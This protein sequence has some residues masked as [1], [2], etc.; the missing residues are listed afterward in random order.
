MKILKTIGLVTVIL[1]IAVL[2]IRFFSGSEDIWLCQN[3]QWIKHGQPSA[4]RPIA[5]C[6]QTE[7]EGEILVTAPLAN[8]RVNSPIKVQGRARGGWFFEASFPAQLLFQG[9]IISQ[10][11]AR[12][13]GDW[14]TNDFVP[15][16]ATLEPDLPRLWEALGTSK[17]TDGIELS[18]VIVLKR[19]NPS[20][21]PQYDKKIEIP[22]LISVDSGQFI[23]V[24][25][26]FNNGN[27][28]PAASCDKVFPVS[29]RVAKTA[30]VAQAALTEVLAGPS[31]KEKEQ[32]YFTNINPGVKIQKL[33]IKEGVARVDFDQ[34][35]AEAVGGSCRVSAIRAQITGTLKQFATVKD[36]II[37][38]NGRSQDIL[39]P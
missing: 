30:A 19:D 38:I 8:Q 18:A 37:S 15:F 7:P 6:G 31:D 24:K 10:T 23:M 20:G 26:F 21:L 12:A 11:M 28:D 9:E 34:T 22:V 35:L 33:T 29:R 32:G 2:A 4:L 25:A 5:N 27:L 17:M 14:M 39:Q 13:K 1:I 36:V 3:G 16:E